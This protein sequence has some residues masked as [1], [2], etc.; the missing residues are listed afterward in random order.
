MSKLHDNTIVPQGACEK[1]PQHV[2]IIMD[3]NGRWAT[4]R[5]KERSF[6]HIE[7][8][9]ALRRT[10][11]AAAKAGI[12]DLT[13]YAFSSENWARPSAEVDAL[14]N[15]MAQSLE[16]YA[17]EFAAEG[18]RIVAIGDLNRLPETT[19]QAVERT[20]VQT[21]HNTTITL[22]VSLSYSSRWELNHAFRT[23]AHDVAS[24]KIA[25]EDLSMEE[26]LAP[27]LSTYGIPDPDLLIRTGGE[28]RI[29][30]FLLYQIAYSELYFSP[31]LWPDFGEQDLQEALCEFS[32]RHR[33]FGLV[34]GQN[35]TQLNPNNAT[36]A[37]NAA[38]QDTL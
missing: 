29:S 37:A 15:L 31:T 23:L 33:R 9:T 3:G 17:P 26:P 25:P 5:G 8:V 20:M 38:P 16:Y 13:V 27:Y 12:K 19:R 2:A 18:V 1:A 34:E 22:V 35:A 6:G 24:G 10:V 30:N 7:G 11:A 21:A 32:Q 36:S 28:L 4:A 14:M